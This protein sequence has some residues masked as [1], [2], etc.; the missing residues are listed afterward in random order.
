M[1]ALPEPAIEGNLGTLRHSEQKNRIRTESY[2][3]CGGESVFLIRQLFP[4]KS[5]TNHYDENPVPTLAH[6]NDKV[7]RPFGEALTS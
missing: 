6:T 5:K 2:L 3:G 1:V 4:N 7:K